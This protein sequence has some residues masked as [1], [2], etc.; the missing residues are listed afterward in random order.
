MGV[1]TMDQL[2]DNLGAADIALT[3]EELAQL[4]RASALP[5]LY[6]YRMIEQYAMRTANP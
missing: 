2:E 6:P 4:D 1:R 5:E 3:A